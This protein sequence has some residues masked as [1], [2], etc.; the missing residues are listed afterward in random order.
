MPLREFPAAI[1]KFSIQVYK[2]PVDEERLYETHIAFSG[3]PQRH[4]F[5]PDKVIIVTDPFSRNTSYFEFLTADI[6]YVEELSTSV[7]IAG[8]AIPMVR[9]WVQKGSVAIRSTPFVVADTS[10]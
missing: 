10:W 6:A 1:K 9:V 4:F 8:H 5:D 3:S 7:D 2:R